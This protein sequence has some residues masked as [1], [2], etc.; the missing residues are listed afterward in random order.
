MLS[1]GTCLIRDL[2]RNSEHD[3]LLEYRYILLTNGTFK[4]LNSVKF[5]V[6]VVEL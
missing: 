6:Q 4:N 2:V 3:R 5:I 1:L